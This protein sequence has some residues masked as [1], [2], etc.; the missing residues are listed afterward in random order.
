MYIFFP[1]YLKGNLS[2]M[3]C[4]RRREARDIEARNHAERV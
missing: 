1:F 4:T 3:C 2:Q